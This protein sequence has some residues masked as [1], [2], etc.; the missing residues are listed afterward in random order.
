MFHYLCITIDSSDAFCIAETLRAVA[1]SRG[2]IPANVTCSNCEKEAFNI[3]TRD[4][5][6][7]PITTD[8]NAAFADQCGAAFV[9]GYT[10][11]GISQSASTTGSGANNGAVGSFPPSIISVSM[12]MIARWHVDGRKAILRDYKLDFIALTNLR[13]ASSTTSEGALL[14]VSADTLFTCNKT[15]QEAR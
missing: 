5:A 13:A 9:D 3:I 8:L 4:Y 15:L 6:R 2:R 7:P 1:S 10:P 11:S 14:D 12:V